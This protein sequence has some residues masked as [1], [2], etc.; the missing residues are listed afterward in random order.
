MLTHLL[1]EGAVPEG[2]QRTEQGAILAPAGMAASA[3]PGFTPRSLAINPRM[4]PRKRATG[5]RC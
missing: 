4:P 5:S 3:D 2:M 1:I